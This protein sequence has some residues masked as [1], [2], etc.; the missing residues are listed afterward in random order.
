MLNDEDWQRIWEEAGELRGPTKG[1]REPVDLRAYGSTC[2]NPACGCLLHPVQTRDGDSVCFACGWVLDSG[3]AAFT[4]DDVGR[5]HRTYFG[6]NPLFHLNERIANLN[7]SDP[8]LPDD[9]FA[10]VNVAHS[11]GDFPTD[12]SLWHGH[13]GKI[14][15]SIIVPPELQEKYRGRRYTCSALTDMCRKF[16]ERWITLRFRLTGIRPPRL[17]PHVIKGLQQ[18]LIGFISPWNKL[19]HTGECKGGLR[20]HKRY[21]CRFK[22]PDCALLIWLFLTDYDPTAKL[23]EL[24]APFLFY[25]GKSPMETTSER[26]LQ[27][28]ACCF[29]WNRQVASYDTGD[30]RWILPEHRGREWT[31]FEEASDE[32]DGTEDLLLSD[33]QDEYELLHVLED[34]IFGL[35]G[36]SPARV[37]ETVPPLDQFQ[38]T[39]C[40]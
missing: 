16:H 26:M 37:S 32:D 28:I 7:C 2:A 17:D 19:R 39:V 8:H 29:R 34:E 15:R 36:G 4:F 40:D 33:R 6:Y 10:L 5:T 9:L 11:C 1:S 30:D 21:K 27:L 12:G 31:R 38:E 35:A 14:L 20:C 25:N 3:L 13:I 22:L 23:A 18:R 24:Y